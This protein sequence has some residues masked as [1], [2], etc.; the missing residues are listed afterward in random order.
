MSW[1]LSFF[2]QC[3]VIDKYELLKEY[4]DG[5]ISLARNEVLKVVA[6]ISPL[7]AQRSFRSHTDT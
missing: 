7:H 1:F 4:E 2:Q 6:N 3:K 5:I